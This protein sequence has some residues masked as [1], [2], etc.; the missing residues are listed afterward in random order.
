MPAAMRPLARVATSARNW[1]AVTSCQLP[2]PVRLRSM[3][4]P[5]SALARR[6]IT[7]VTLADAGISARAGLLYSRNGPAFRWPRLPGM[8]LMRALVQIGM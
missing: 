5:G 8:F 1:L 7:S 2:A 4:S 6:K 3:T